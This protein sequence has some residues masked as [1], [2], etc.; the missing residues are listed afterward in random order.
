MMKLCWLLLLMLISCGTFAQRGVI[1]IKKKGYKKV[2]SYAEGQQIHFRNHKDEH[3]KGMI[4]I[5]RNDSIMVDG[6]MH[7]VGSISRIYVREKSRIGREVLITTGGI[8][9]TSGLMRLAG[10]SRF[11]DALS[12]NAVLGY[13]NILVR[14][15]SKFKRRQYIIGRKFSIQALDLRF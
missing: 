7:A 2:A 5:V 14:N 11:D 10:W 6:Q 15:L 3:V 4:W 1:F 12:H 8:I 13:G 9:A